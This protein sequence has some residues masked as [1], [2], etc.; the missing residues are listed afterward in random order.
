MTEVL[1][2]INP[3][4]FISSATATLAAETANRIISTAM[5]YLG[6][7]YRSGSSDP[8]GFDCSGFTSYVFKKLGISL[9]RSSRE[10]FTMGTGIDDIS[11]LRRGDLV[12]FGNG[13]NVNHVGIV[14]EADNDNRTFSFIHASSSQGVTID[15][16]PA[17]AY[18]RSH[19]ISAR[20]ILP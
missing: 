6:T 13:R 2:T 18:W 8:K 10:Q 11:D 17:S 19:Y 1:G 5:T 4:I 15:S 7:R 20:R 14:T 9:K 12:F 3:V 16:Y